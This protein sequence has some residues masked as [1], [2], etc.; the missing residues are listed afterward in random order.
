VATIGFAIMGFG[1]GLFIMAGLGADPVTVLAQGIALNTGI[2][3]GR[4]NQLVSL[5]L[6][7]AVLIVD[8]SKLGVGT[9]INA[10]VVG[11]AMDM[12]LAVLGAPAGAVAA[13]AMLGLGILLLGLGVGIY[14]STGVGQGSV[15][16]AMTILAERLRVSVGFTRIIID[17]SS[18]I[19]GTLLG[20]GFGPGTV[21]GALLTGPVAALTIG[22]IARFGGAR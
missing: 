1:I 8:R 6:L 13:W 4:A 21:V 22:L 10:I 9:L 12:S 7:L 18:V 14:V 15:E 2:T 11:W 16:G 20:A 19:A 5:G 3:V 17:V